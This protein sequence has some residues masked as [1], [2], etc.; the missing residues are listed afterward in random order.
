MFR[1]FLINEL[2]S[3]WMLVQAQL[4][5]TAVV[6]ERMA[7]KVEEFADTGGLWSLSQLSGHFIEKPSML[8]HYFYYIL[9]V[10]GQLGHIDAEVDKILRRSSHAFRILIHAECI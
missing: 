8:V 10:V 1:Q 5:Q 2:V 3:G 7:E 6:G 9:H 4:L